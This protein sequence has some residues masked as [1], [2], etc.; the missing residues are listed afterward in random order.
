MEAVIFTLPFF[1]PF[2]IAFNF[3]FALTVATFLSE[4]FHVTFFMVV[5]FFWM[6]IVFVLPLLILA[7]FVS[8]GTAVFAKAISP[9]IGDRTNIVA[10]PIERNFLIF[11]PCFF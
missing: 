4:D 9:V 2:T 11:L 6:V 5:P 10:I 8:A 7:L 1:M 3:P